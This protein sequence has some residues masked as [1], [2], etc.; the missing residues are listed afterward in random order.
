LEQFVNGLSPDTVADSFDVDEVATAN[1]GAFSQKKWR[2]EIKWT[3]LRKPGRL[4]PR[5]GTRHGL[6]WAKEEQADFEKWLK[7][8]G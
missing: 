4:A 6:A 8:G 5:P 7:S 1:Q 3:R 2:P